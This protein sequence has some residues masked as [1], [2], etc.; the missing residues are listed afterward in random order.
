MNSLFERHEVLGEGTYGVVFRATMKS[1]QQMVALKQMRRMGRRGGIPAAAREVAFLQS[2]QDHP[3]IVRL[4]DVIHNQ[5]QLWLSFELCDSDL[6]AAI[7]TLPA[8]NL[9]RQLFRAIAHCH[10][11]RVIHRD[12]KPQNILLKGTILK[13]ADFGLAR[14]LSLPNQQNTNQVVTLWYRAP[15]LLLGDI[16]YTPAVDIWAAGCVVAEMLAG[17]PLFPGT[18]ELDTLFKIF[19]LFGTPV[20]PGCPRANNQKATVAWWNGVINLP[21]WNNLF[22]HWPGRKVDQALIG[23]LP[24]DTP[25]EA[26]DLLSKLLV[27]DPNKRLTAAEALDHPWLKEDEKEDKN[28]SENIVSTEKLFSSH[29]IVASDKKFER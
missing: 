17:K 4:I 9:A 27:L 23:I 24:K 3:N 10:V 5:S 7:N 28:L 26:I 16:N 11:N 25:L 8:R 19:R 18:S 14:A 13:L 29:Q 2:L 1:T 22:P 15:E 20:H 12:I 21:H 6:R